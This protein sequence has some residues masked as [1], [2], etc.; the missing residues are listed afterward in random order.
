MALPEAPFGGFPK[1]GVP[2]LG[3]H[4]IRTIV[5][6]GLYW[7]LP[8]LG[9]YH[10]VT[11]SVAQDSSTRTLDGDSGIVCHGDTL[12]GPPHPVIVVY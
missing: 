10:L 1:L 3:I 9:I 12:G 11:T 5:F 4:I 7:G 8:I 2:F 6:W